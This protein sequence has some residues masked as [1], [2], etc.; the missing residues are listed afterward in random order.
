VLLHH[1]VAPQCTQGLRF[2]H[3]D[4]L[5]DALFSRLENMSRAVGLPVPER[6]SR[7]VGAAKVAAVRA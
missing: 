6:R 1:F 7:F 4:Q 2:E 5:P 3:S